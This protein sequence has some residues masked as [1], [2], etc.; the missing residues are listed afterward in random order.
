M[1]QTDSAQESL[2]KELSATAEKVAGRYAGMGR[3]RICDVVIIPRGGFIVRF[4]LENGLEVLLQPDHGAPLVSFQSW[5]K[6]GSVNEKPGRTGIAHLFEHLMFKGTPRYPHHEFDRLFEEAGAQT[7]AAT[8]LD[9]TFY[10]EN[11][12]S[13]SLDL[14]FDLES[15]RMRNLILDSVQLESERDVV[16]SERCY[17]VD[18]DP[19]GQIEEAL[20]E[21]LFPAHPYGQPTLG[22]FQDIDAISLQDCSDFYDRYY[23]PSNALLVIVGDCTF[24]R[25]L[26]LCFSRYGH[27]ESVPPPAMDIPAIPAAAGATTELKLDV[28][29]ERLRIGWL[30][31]S[32]G[33]SDAVVLD[34]ANEILFSNESSRA[35]RHLI[36]DLPLAS[37]VD[38]TSEPMRL[39]GTFIVDIVINEGE[40]AEDALDV[41]FQEIESLAA[42]GPAEAELARAC[43]HL[44]ASFLRS[45]VTVGSRATQ[46]GIWHV[47]TGDYRQLFSFVHDVRSVNA[48]MVK[49]VVAKYLVRDLAVSVLARPTLPGG[50]R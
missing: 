10:Y 30:T 22:T 4:M 49:E 13:E 18:N 25:A 47:T 8:W 16:R 27:L 11:I 33:S 7:N 28:N 24:E 21:H 31:V 14:A 9:W 35:Y 38:G 50:E 34:V 45:M 19:D 37:D 15:D 48:S 44:E 12:P 32:A 6:V 42:N 17:R 36:D 1:I 3:I 43:N 20:F 5:F 23:S 26:D 39:G 2:I 46:L 40:K 41:V 29:S